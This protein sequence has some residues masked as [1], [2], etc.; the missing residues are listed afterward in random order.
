[1]DPD[2]WRRVRAL[3]EV[4]GSDV[5]GVALEAKDA[6]ELTQLASQGAVP[7]SAARTI[8]DPVID[9]WRHALDP[10]I[11]SERRRSVRAAMDGGA[12]PAGLTVAELR[13]LDPR[14]AQRTP[15]EQI[16]VRAATG[17]LSGTTQASAKQLVTELAALEHAPAN[18]PDELAEL[19][20]QT[21]R[22]VDAN[23]QRI[24]GTTPKGEVRGYGSHPDYA[25]VGRIRAN[26]ELIRRMTPPAFPVSASDDAAGAAHAGDDLLGW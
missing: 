4:V 1:L 21:R 13:D 25:Q 5:D 7:G 14:W 20:R 6:H 10:S 16:V 24:R 19:W 15:F 8:E 2:R 17:E 12:L 23:L 3:F 11:I 9:R 26:I 18:M 22:L